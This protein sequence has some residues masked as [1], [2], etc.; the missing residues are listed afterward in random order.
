[1]RARSSLALSRLSELTSCTTCSFELY[2]ADDEWVPMHEKG[3]FCASSSRSPRS[4]TA[5]AT[6]DPPS[7]TLALADGGAVK[8]MTM[9][10]SWYGQHLP[11]LIKLVL[12]RADQIVAEGKVKQPTLVDPHPALVAEWVRKGKNPQNGMELAKEEG[13]DGAEKGDKA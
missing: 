5:R 7:L 3:G 11:G 4:R 6:A 2:Q 13:E 1:M 8:D 12:A 9:S 10:N